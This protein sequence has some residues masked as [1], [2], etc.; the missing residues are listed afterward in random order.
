MLFISNP[1]VAA[2]QPA[3]S[4]YA[5]LRSVDTNFVHTGVIDTAEVANLARW[6]RIIID[7]A[8]ND[9]NAAVLRLLRLDNAA[10]KLLMFSMG[11]KCFVCGQGWYGV[12][13]V[14]YGCDTR[15]NN[16]QWA[17]WKAIRAKNAVL[18]SKVN[19]GA[20]LNSIFVDFAM[21]G[22]ARALADTTYSWEA[23]QAGTFSGAFIDEICT[24]IVWTQSYG[25]SIDFT[26][27]GFATI[28]QWDSAY[29]ENVGVFFDR[30]RG[31]LPAGATLVGN[32]GPSGQR[33]KVYGWM[34]EN[35]PLQNGATWAS[36]M[37]I[38]GT[39][40]GYMPD[41]SL[42][43][44]PSMCWITTP[45][46]S[47]NQGDLELQR[48]FRFT[49]GSSCLTGGSGTVVG[50]PYDPLR[51]YLPW[52]MDEFAVNGSGVAVNDANYKHWLGEPLGLAYQV[53]TI[54]RRDFQYGI[55]LVNP[56]TSSVLSTVGSGVRRI[57]GTVCP[58]VNNGVVASKVTV[59]ANDA[60][61]LQKY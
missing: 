51:G 26:R 57:A 5:Q 36:N 20:Y 17:K 39:D 40:P 61:F 8:R 12:T 29:K 23:Q 42:Y 18:H 15:A 56:T 59:P 19:G 38:Y 46:G 1:V 44:Q 43:L 21:P 50:G 54:W 28:A 30:L 53:G 3:L 25:D 34:R 24:S 37:L 55:V 32:C 9:P 60:L 48:K 33:T 31:W 7:P 16:F 13:P 47:Y 4:M 35:F 2:P 22:I 27:S 49:F 14:P 58:T 11:G 41:D 10:N 52:W 6:D 45:K